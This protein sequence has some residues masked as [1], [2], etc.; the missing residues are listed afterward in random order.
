MRHE[1]PFKTLRLLIIVKSID[2]GTGTF[3]E[4]FLKLEKRDKEFQPIIKTLVLEK[5]AFRAIKKFNAGFFLGKNAYPERY[6]AV[7]QNF[8]NICKEFV[9]VKKN[10]DKFKPQ[11]VLSIDVHSNLLALFYKTLSFGQIKVIAATHIDLLETL[12]GKSTPFIKFLLKA[13]VNIFY[14]RA[15]VL[16][17]VSK[18]VSHNL[19]HDFNLSKNVIT[20]YNGIATPNETETRERIVGIK[21]RN[22]KKIII[23]I[24]R[25]VEQKDNENLIEAFNLLQNKLVGSK[26]WILGDGSKKSDLESLVRKYRLQKKVTFFGWIKNTKGHLLKSS[27]FVL[28]SKREGLPYVL[29]EAMRCGLPVISTDSPWGPKEILD[30]GKYGILVPVGKP[31][32]MSKAIYRLLTDAQK[33]SYYSKKSVERSV[34]F[35]VD[36]MLEEYKKILIDIC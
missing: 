1:I 24:T 3:I 7:P 15:D 26:L 34:F 12:S 10:I 20:I 31:N 25:L 2:G 8:I 13:V 29:L 22:N 5:P 36:K 6:E 4:N 16:V 28:S 18:G 32:T 21:P 30:N 33:Y 9:W 17:G 14:N 27:I 19:K 11:I 35:S 23:T